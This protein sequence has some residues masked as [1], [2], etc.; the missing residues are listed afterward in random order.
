[1]NESRGVMAGEGPRQVPISE[2]MRLATD[3]HQSGRLREAEAIYRAV[4]EAEPE[5]SGASYNLGLIAL[6]SGQPGQAVPVFRAALQADPDNA[7]FWMNYA[8]ALA[9]SGE[10]AAA[11]EALLQARQRGIGGDAL[12]G[13]LAQVE[14]MMRT[15]QPTL[16]ETVDPTNNEGKRIINLSPLLR[17]YD[18]GRFAEVEARARELMSDFPD[19]APLVRLLGSCLL[20]LQ[21]YEQSSEVLTQSS[22][23]IPN[24]PLILYLLGLALRRLRRNEDARTAFDQS[25]AVA[26]DNFDTLLNASANAVTLGDPDEARRYAEHALAL[27]PDNVDALRVLADAEAAGGRTEEATDLYRRAIALD[28]NAIDLYTNLGDAL[29]SLGRADEATAELRRALELRADYAPAHLSMG[30]ALYELG[31]TAS[32]S[33]HFRMASDLAPDMPE[34][35]TAYL[36]SLAHNETITPEQSFQEHLRV[37]GRIEAPHRPAWPQHDSD[38]DPER[39]LR[40]GFVSGDLRDHPVAYLIEPV[41]QAMRGGNHK[42]F[43]YANAPWEDAVSERLRA[44]TDVWV[45]VE[46]MDDDTLYERI[47][48]DRIDIL[49]D[50]SG[51]T[52]RNRLTVFAR[53][54]API[55]VSWIGYPG[56]TG[57]T[58]VDYRF[59][60]ETDSGTGRREEL[61]CEKF[62]RF[63]F[64]AFQ[65]EASAPLVNP[66]PALSGNPLTFG[67][68]N[69]PSKLSEGVIALWSRVLRAIPGS[70]LLIAAAGE[71]RL[72]ARLRASFAGHGVASER[73][74]FRPRLPMPQYLALHHE[75]DIALD[76]FPYAG[77]TTTGHALWMGVPVL[78]LAG[79]GLQQ[80]QAAA[81]LKML[82]MADWVTASEE[83]FVTQAVTAASR[84]EEV[85]ELRQG[86]RDRMSRLFQGSSDD[87]A[88]ELDA[89][90][91]TMWR[92]WCA[93]L[94]PESFTVQA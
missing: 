39:G 38:R 42:V 92:R 33:E 89:A 29:T 26:A 37:G 54:P 71:E 17:L 28:R 10:P 3:H 9:G 49:F 93:G 59:V 20:A 19:S 56:T 31:E 30:R 41:W 11:R 47:R 52:T 84:L 50:L 62:V 27:R 46:R 79:V 75:V 63:Q 1:M 67:S 13:V 76:T 2:A 73:L 94:A 36:F 6:Q 8:V 48:A 72:K 85:A 53:K 86:L 82:D 88:R 91:R 64:R 18:E 68:F 32:A 40:V 69:R 61:F 44:L 77:G 43:A 74:A 23:R 70:R 90:F 34:A 83:A 15:R 60:R 58:A 5:H 66:L 87:F 65:H 55:Q 12:S 35:H 21:K 45:R 24:D 7:A 25:L 78:T 57:L 22:K 51:H 80:N 14:R 4:L 16:V 81:V